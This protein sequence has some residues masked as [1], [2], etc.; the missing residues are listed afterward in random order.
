MPG[1]FRLMSGIHH[2]GYSGVLAVLLLVPALSAA[3]TPLPESETESTASP[4]VVF[5]SSTASLNVRASEG[6]FPADRAAVLL[7]EERRK[8]ADSALDSE[9]KLWMSYMWAAPVVSY[10]PLYFEETQ[11][12]RYGHHHGVLQPMVS[13][14]HFFGRIVALPYKAGAT[15]CGS[16]QYP[17]GH[18][19]PGDNVPDHCTQPELS[20]RGTIYEAIVITGGVFVIP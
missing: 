14:S 10:R 18:Y 20:V 19:R 16:C 6:P 11:L 3:E 8:Q 4:G 2:R 15:P 5:V 9:G 1:I 7:D 13:A 17:L 12:E